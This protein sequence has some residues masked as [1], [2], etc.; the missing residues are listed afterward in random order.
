MVRV[1]KRRYLYVVIVLKKSVVCCE[2][3]KDVQLYVVNAL[4]LSVVC[5]G[6]NV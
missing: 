2:C 6:K 3:L 4:K 5:Y 1:F